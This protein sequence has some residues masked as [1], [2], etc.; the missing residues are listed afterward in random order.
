MTFNIEDRT[1][2]AYAKREIHNEVRGRFSER[3]AGEIDIV[4]SELCSNLI[5]HAG[6]GQILFRKLEQR[7]IDIV[8][9]FSLDNGGG[10]ADAHKM[11]K[12]GMST[13]NTLGHGL[14]HT[15]QAAQT[16][17]FQWFCSLFG[18]IEKPEAF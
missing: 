5:K 9:I 3:R 16:N 2:V 17:M 4:V 6:G 10:M 18:V 13:S 8:E 1:F 11:V 12:D 15:A 14:A 7:G